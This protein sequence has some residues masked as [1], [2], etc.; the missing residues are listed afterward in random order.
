MAGVLDFL[1]QGTP[2]ASVTNYGATS[3]NI[4]TYMS[5]Y[6]L[7][8]LNKASSVAGADYQPYDQPRL[9]NFDPSQEKAFQ[10]TIDSTGKFM[11]QLT[12][13]VDLAKQ[14]GATSGITAANPLLD[15]AATYDPYAAGI[16]NI[17]TASAMNPIAAAQP[18]I[19]MASK[20][21][22]DVIDQYMNPYTDKVVN[23]IADLAQRNLTENFLPQVNN[24]FVRSG[25]L[26]SRGEQ[27]A[28]G[29]TL[30][31]LQE[32]TLAEQAKALE[33]G[34]GAATTA[35]QTDLGRQGTLASTVG[36]LNVNEQNALGALG[37]DAGKL[38]EA[39]QSGLGTVGQIKGNLTNADAT[40]KINAATSLT[41]IGNAQQ[42]QNLKD[43]AALEAV[44][45]TKRDLDQKNLDLAYQD[46]LNQKNYTADQLAM[47]NSLIRGLPYSTTTNTAKTGEASSY[48]PSPL[49]TLAASSSLYNSL[50]SGVP[51]KEGGVIRR[52][53]N[54]RSTR[55]RR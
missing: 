32:S 51:K 25:V 52:N 28:L 37:T 36:N 24:T 34:Y 10:N 19:S 21:A 13:G 48:G 46:F 42:A 33:S 54:R 41:N 29:R 3:S 4:P 49:Q 12:A 53:P 2:P 20:T 1:F 39:A 31:N 15:K 9:A 50:N 14:A 27:E 11:P 7:G 38:A 45:Q 55:G 17:N 16:G 40:N 47:M 30:R 18:L 26:G 43:Q 44:G 6:V 5:D 35:A 8:L 23:R 22:P